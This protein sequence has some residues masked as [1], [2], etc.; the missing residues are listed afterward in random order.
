MTK[1]YDATGLAAGSYDYKVIGGNS[2]GPGP[3]SAVSTIVVA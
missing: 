1:T 3:E 2:Q